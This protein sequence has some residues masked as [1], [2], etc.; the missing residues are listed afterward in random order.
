MPIKMQMLSG[1]HRYGYL[2]EPEG[3]PTG[4]IVLLP[5]IF[6]INDFARSYAE[7]LASAG[8]TTAVW[9][10]YAGRPLPKDYDEAISRAR[11]LRDDEVVASIGKW[12]DHMLGEMQLSAVGVLGF[13]IG[14]RFAILQ[15]AHDKRIKACA[16]AYPSIEHPRLANQDRDALALAGEIA[17]PVLNIQPGKDHVSQPDTYAVLNKALFSRRAATTLHYYPVAEHG[18]MHRPQPAENRAATTLVSPQLMAFLVACLGEEQAAQVR[19]FAA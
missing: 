8:L 17:C 18:F 7:T 14:G 5:T 1:P 2:A 4:G 13:C 12:I 19:N 11:G 6:A 10:I 9:D 16:M 3:R 15:C